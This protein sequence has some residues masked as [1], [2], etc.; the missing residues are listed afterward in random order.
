MSEETDQKLGGQVGIKNIPQHFFEIIGGN[1]TNYQNAIKDNRVVNV[2]EKL[3]YVLGSKVRVP[4]GS[5]VKGSKFFMNEYKDAFKH[6]LGLHILYNIEKGNKIT[7][8]TIDLAIEKLKNGNNVEGV[9]GVK[10]IESA[11]REKWSRIYGKENLDAI[12]SKYKGV[13]IRAK[14]NKEAAKELIY[15]D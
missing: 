4:N 6:R 11:L 8:K 13:D 10:S 2:L 12:I 3:D 9:L 1:V 5:W 15:E 14:E 7:H